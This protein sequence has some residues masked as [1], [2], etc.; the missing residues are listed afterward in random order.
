[1]VG[2]GGGGGGGDYPGQGCLREVEAHNHV[3]RHERELTS[4]R[5]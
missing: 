1:M 4:E 5:Y 2:G 3:L